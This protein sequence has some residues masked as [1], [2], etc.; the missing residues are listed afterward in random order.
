M[1]I[2]TY[3]TLM[4][5]LLHIA[6][7]C[8]PHTLRD[9]TDA[10]AD[11][12]GLS[13]DDRAALTPS[14]KQVKFN[15][16]VQVAKTHLQKAGLVASEG[17]GTFRITP[18]GLKVLATAPLHIDRAFLMQFPAFVDYV[19]RTQPDAADLSPDAE[20]PD[21]SEATH[22][23]KELLHVIHGGLQSELA[24]EII[25]EVLAS[26]PAFFERLVVDLLRAMGYG[27][28]DVDAAR[29][30][31]RSGD[32]GVDGYIRE[33]KLGLHGIYIQAKRYARHQAVGRPAVQ[34]FVGSLIG[35]GAKKG[36]LMTT[37]RF[38]REAITYAEGMQDHDVILIDG[39]RLAELMIEHNVGVAV[40]ATYTVK[41]VDRG[42]F[43]PE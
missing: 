12:V 11:Y 28:R 25:D 40:E 13:E 34:A 14:G 32:G 38:T 8:E 36:V 5:P 2:P 26:S 17:R 27:G 37:S 31:G 19:T 43:E 20:P 6:A 24:D 9:A 18:L 15:Y 42:Y 39:T 29:T 35:K 4:L 7:D 33:D 21:I 3:A 1:P 41:R 30:V 10:L 22:T 23:P 16:R